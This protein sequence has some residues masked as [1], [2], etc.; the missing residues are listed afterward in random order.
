MSL[1]LAIVHSNYAKIWKKVEFSDKIDSIIF[2]RKSFQF[3]GI[4]QLSLKVREVIFTEKSFE[5]SELTQISISSQKVIIGECAF[6]SNLNL[7]KFEISE[8]TEN[9]AIGSEAFK[10]TPIEFISILAK[11]S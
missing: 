7:S 5:Y 11:K 4:K 2:G 3:A 6:S 8:E 9:L 10:H 1:T